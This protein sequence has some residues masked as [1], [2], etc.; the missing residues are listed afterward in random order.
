[1]NNT[2]LEATDIEPKLDINC[3][4]IPQIWLVYWLMF[5]QDQLRC[6]RLGE[7]TFGI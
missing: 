1:V 7:I 3:N 2:D 6:C 5:F 4:I